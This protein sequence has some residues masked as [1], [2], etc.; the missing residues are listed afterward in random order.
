[1]TTDRYHKGSKRRSVDFLIYLILSL[2]EFLSSI[3]YPHFPIVA[4]TFLRDREG[5]KGA[6]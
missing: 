4:P 2:P 6:S 3:F 1:M 5:L